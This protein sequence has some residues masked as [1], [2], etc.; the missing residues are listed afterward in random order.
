M[1]GKTYSIY[2]R[3]YGKAASGTKF[4]DRDYIAP[5]R[6]RMFERPYDQAGQLAVSLAIQDVCLLVPMKT[7]AEVEQEVQRLLF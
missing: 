4:T 1:K 6:L 2:V 5:A 3:A 7:E